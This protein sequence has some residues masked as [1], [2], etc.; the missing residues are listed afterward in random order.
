MVCNCNHQLHSS[1]P[2]AAQLPRCWRG[3]AKSCL[4][5]WC[6]V[7]LTLKGRMLPRG[8]RPATRHSSLA[9]SFRKGSVRTLRPTNAKPSDRAS[10]LHF[11]PNNPSH[12]WT[13]P[14]ATLV[15]PC[16]LS[17]VGCPGSGPPS[18]QSNPGGIDGSTQA[19]HWGP[20]TGE[21]VPTT[22]MP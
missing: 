1:S 12:V 5:K 6:G 4:L 7:R 22:V 13:S 9:I 8:P 20:Q 14:T 18:L 3:L 16:T 15:P 19:Q 17:H 21:L 11:P 10:A 2:G